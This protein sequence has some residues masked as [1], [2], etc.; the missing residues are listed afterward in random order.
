MNANFPKRLA[1]GALSRAVD[2]K[3]ETIRYYEKIGLI[4]SPPRSAG[5]NRIYGTD[6]IHRLRFVR[7]CRE[8]GFALDDIR[9]LLSLAEAND[10]GCTR[11]KEITET[12]LRNVRDKLSSLRR[13]E[14]SLKTMTEACAPGHQR[15][16]PI[17]EALES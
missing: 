13:L 6:D 16:C 8:L 12:H 11:T 2:V 10:P 3:I 5:G 9:E 4:E 14:R 1:I 15:S 17:I 7:R